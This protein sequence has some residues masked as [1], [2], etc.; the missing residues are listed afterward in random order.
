MT[1]TYQYATTSKP[2]VRQAWSVLDGTY[3]ETIPDRELDPVVP[4]GAGWSLV[5]SAANAKTLFWTWRRTKK[6]ILK[7][8]R[9]ERAQVAHTLR[10]YDG[11]KTKA[12]YALGIDR[13][14]LQRKMERWG[15]AGGATPKATR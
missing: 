4:R 7:L 13:K 9:A 6:A 14:T 11:N 3:D 1:T 15:M 2:L 5:S 12:A 8:D 10:F